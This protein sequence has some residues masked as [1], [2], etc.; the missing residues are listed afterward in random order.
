VGHHDGVGVV[1][2]RPCGAIKLI[3]FAVFR[4]PHIYDLRTDRPDQIG[5][6]CAARVTGQVDPGP[7]FD[8]DVLQAR[9]AVQ[10]GHPA[11]DV[12]VGAVAGEGDG[13]DLAEAVEGRMGRVA[14]GGFDVGLEA[15]YAAPGLANR[16]IS[17]STSAGSGR[18]TS[19]VRA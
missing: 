1:E 15:G 13:E 3:E 7:R 19:S 5:P 4:Q 9:L 14:D 16:T 2:V 17:A 12:R 6:D 18:V 11:P 8:G 10:L